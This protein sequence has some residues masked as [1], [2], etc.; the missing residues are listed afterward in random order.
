[1]S[2]P[3]STNN[4]ELP[5]VGSAA[6]GHRPARKTTS[7]TKATGS[8]VP[9]GSSPVPGTAATSGSRCSPL[10]GA[11]EEPVE[12]RTE[13]VWSL[14]ATRARSVPVVP[15]AGDVLQLPVHLLGLLPLKTALRCLTADGSLAFTVTS[16]RALWVALRAS[17]GIVFGL[18]ELEA[19]TCAAYNDRANP[20]SLRLWCEYKTQS[21]AW[22]LTGSEA[23][24][25]INSAVVRTAPETVTLGDVLTAW[26]A[27]LVDAEVL[28]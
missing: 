14:G 13:R 19:L 7:R 23:L 1:M 10:R 9:S 18:L 6:T 12:H 17:G 20:D 2:R 5:I 28:T 15:G 4:M 11:P 3:R 22:K 25:S 27:V 24:G 16:C 8:V 26:G 21:P